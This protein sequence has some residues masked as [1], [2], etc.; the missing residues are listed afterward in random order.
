MRG[1]L[2]IAFPGSFFRKT[3]EKLP[4]PLSAKLPV[5]DI[6]KVSADSYSGK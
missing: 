1:S 3:A 6:L 5:P 4:D 2:G